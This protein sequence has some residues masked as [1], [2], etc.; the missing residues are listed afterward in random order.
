MLIRVYTFCPYYLYFFFSSAWPLF[1]RQPLI[2]RGASQVWT[3]VLHE[4]LTRFLVANQEL[5]R[6][7]GRSNIDLLALM[8]PVAPSKRPRR[9]PLNTLYFSWKHPT[10]FLQTSPPSSTFWSAPAQA[11]C[12]PLPFRSLAP[13]SWLSQTKGALGIRYQPPYFNV[14]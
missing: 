12:R 14:H 11:F 9:Q 3:P 1:G 7:V 2:C 6:I 5:Y 13:L 10:V 8:I 4:K